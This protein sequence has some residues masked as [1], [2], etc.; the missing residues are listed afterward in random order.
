MKDDEIY[1]AGTGPDFEAL[2]KKEQEKNQSLEQENKALKNSIL[3]ESGSGSP[4]S[5]ADHEGRFTE[6]SG[7]RRSFPRPSIAAQV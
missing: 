6:D 2:L 3:L 1:A 4:K 7:C 5:V